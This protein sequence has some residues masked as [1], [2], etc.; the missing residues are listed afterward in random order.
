MT[1]NAGLSFELTAE[2]RSLR[3]LA[4]DFAEK[5]IRPRA[6]EYDENQTHPTDV[7]ERAHA[8]GLMN[9]H[10]PRACGGPALGLLEGALI[11]EEL[12]WGCAGIGTALTCNGLGGGPLIAA[13]TAEQQRQWLSPLLER[14]ILCAF[15]LTEPDAGS[16]V[17]R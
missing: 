3:E 10:V 8:V 12:Y 13:G 7:I 15:G 17:A 11:G 16:D 1:E 4:H 14:P 6:A 9:L 5:E 2:Q